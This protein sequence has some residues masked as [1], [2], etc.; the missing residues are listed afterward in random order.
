MD[1]N[2]FLLNN[3]LIYIENN[4]NYNNYLIKMN[5][6]NYYYYNNNNNLLNPYYNE[7]LLNNIF[8]NKN[9]LHLCYNIDNVWF[10]IIYNKFFILYI[11]FFLYYTYYLNNIFLYLNNIF[12]YNSFY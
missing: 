2:S 11:I 7:L 10:I 5:L 4:I 6:I 9:L 3:Y 12:K 8:V 1:Y